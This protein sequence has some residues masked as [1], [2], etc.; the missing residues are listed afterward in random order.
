MTTLVEHTDDAL[1]TDDEVYQ[2]KGGNV[3]FVF[4][5]LLG[6][7]AVGLYLVATRRVQELNRLEIRGSTFLT[8]NAV[9]FLTT[10]LYQYL[11]CAKVGSQ[12]RLNLHRSA[13]GQRFA[14]NYS[15]MLEN[16]KKPKIH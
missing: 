7:G 5:T 11:Y 3:N 12:A 9:F 15:Y 10:G 13:L 8:A 6:L 1:L 16:K 14:F 2:L 4:K